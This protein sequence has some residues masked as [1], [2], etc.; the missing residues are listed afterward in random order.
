MKKTN[1]RACGAEILMIKM[2]NGKTLPVDPETVSVRRETGGGTYI[3]GE[4]RI[5][6][7]REVG[8]ADDGP[9]EVLE[10]YKSHFVTCPEGGRRR[11]R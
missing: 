11:R 8:D 3:D 2:V 4:G 6:F 5:F 7:G 9:G 1:C 10:L